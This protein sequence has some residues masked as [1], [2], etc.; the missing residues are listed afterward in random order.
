ML[1]IFYLRIMSISLMY[2]FFACLFSLKKVIYLMFDTVGDLTLL[3]Q[4]ADEYV[5]IQDDSTLHM[6]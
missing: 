1:T 3:L 5:V 4:S 2:S 6:N